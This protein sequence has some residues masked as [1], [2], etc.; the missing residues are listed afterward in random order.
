MELTG[1]IVLA[2]VYVRTTDS[3]GRPSTGIVGTIGSADGLSI[4]I[5]RII[6][7]GEGPLIGIV[8]TIDYGD[9]L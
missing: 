7:I 6:Y 5:G 3:G 2:E 4:G 9:C 8:R 1:Q